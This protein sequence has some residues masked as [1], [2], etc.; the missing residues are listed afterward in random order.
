MSEFTV[1]RVVDAPRDVVWRLWTDP[2]ELAHW[3][4]PRGMRTLPESVTVDVRAGGRYAY[5]MVLEDGTGATPAG[6]AYLEVVEPERLVFTWG[7]ADDDSVVEVTLTGRG[8]RTEVSLTVRGV[9]GPDVRDGWTGALDNL[10]AHAAGTARPLATAIPRRGRGTSPPDGESLPIADWAAV[11][12]ALR[13]PQ[14]VMWL[15]TRGPGGHPHVRPVFAAWDGASFFLCSKHAAV[16]SRN[17]R[18]DGHCTVS[19]DLGWLHLVVEA[20]AARVTG[21]DRLTAASRAM[22]EVYDWP[23]EIA[24]DEL[25]APYAAP[26]SGG[27]PFEVYELV[28]RRAY[29]FPTA[30][31]CKPTRWT[32]PA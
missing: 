17:L 23:T 15:A 8:D 27:P 31:Q 11:H 28:P 1:T 3:F 16:K 9:T 12:D 25:D 2:G 30:D 22:L 32:F 18:A 14:G 4:H 19:T 21:P 6:G 13:K 10:A 26:T 24:G 5:T 7:T 29:G 20:E